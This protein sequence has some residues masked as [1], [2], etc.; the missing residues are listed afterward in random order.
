MEDI[1]SREQTHQRLAADQPK[2]RLPAETFDIIFAGDR[3]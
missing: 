1:Q 3:F 2:K